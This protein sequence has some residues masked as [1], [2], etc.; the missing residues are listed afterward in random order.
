MTIGAR[1]VRGSALQWLAGAMSGAL[2]ATGAQATSSPYPDLTIS[3]VMQNSYE[4]SIGGGPMQSAAPT[5]DVRLR[6]NSNVGG[7]LSEVGIDLTARLDGDSFFYLHNG[8]CV[9]TC[10]IAMKTILTFTLANT[11]ASPLDVRWDSLITPG[12]LG[13]VGSDGTGLFHFIL[14]DG[15]DA[16]GIG[17][18]HQESRGETFGWYDDFVLGETPL[19]GFR[20]DTY[21][22]GV[23]HLNAW[24]FADWSATGLNIDLLTI[25]GNSTT[26]LTYHSSVSMAN[27]SLCTDLADC[28]GVQVAFGDPRNTGSVGGR[29]AGPTAFLTSAEPLIGRA[30]DVFTNEA[31]LFVTPDTPLPVPP[32]VLPAVTYGAPFSTPVPPPAVPEPASWAL[33]FLGFGAIGSMLRARRAGASHDVF[34]PAAAH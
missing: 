22:E 30:F 12:H 2:L 6:V 15:N 13:Q 1:G 34:A 32:A 19:A 9:G 4:Y 21:S 23:G 16:T 28:G 3:A 31:Q 7:N 27:S 29:M 20:R 25:P 33:L 11:G 5:G 24:S 8:Y 26:I 14:V 10:S 18:V 17:E